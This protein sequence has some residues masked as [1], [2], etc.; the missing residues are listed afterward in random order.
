MTWFAR[1]NGCRGDFSNL[2]YPLQS[3]DGD[4]RLSGDASCVTYNLV[5]GTGGFFNSD[6]KLLTQPTRWFPGE[7]K[8]EHF[9]LFLCV[10]MSVLFKKIYRSYLLVKLNAPIC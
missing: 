8:T 9:R 7:H 6:K 4:V 3:A 1:I 2:R 5:D 10:L